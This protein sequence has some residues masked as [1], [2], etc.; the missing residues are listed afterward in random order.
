MNALTVPA[1]MARPA[2]SVGPVGVEPRSMSS[3][4]SPNVC[5]D[6]PSM[7]D[8]AV[9]GRLGVE[10]QPG[11]DVVDDHRVLLAVVLGVGEQERQQP[12]AQNSSI[13]QKNE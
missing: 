2:H 13:V 10:L 5:T 11:R 3:T 7:L 8:R 4:R 6:R 9:V 12:V 1:P